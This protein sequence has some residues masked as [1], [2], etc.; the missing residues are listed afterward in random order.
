MASPEQCKVKQDVAGERQRQ[1]ENET[2]C[3]RVIGFWAAEQLGKHGE[4]AAAYVADILGQDME[5]GGRVS[6]IRKIAADLR[7]VG[8]SEQLVKERLSEC[9]SRSEANCKW[10]DSKAGEP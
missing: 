1:F 2:H 4:D 3:D 7:G 5:M 8:I 9:L 10:T 6:V